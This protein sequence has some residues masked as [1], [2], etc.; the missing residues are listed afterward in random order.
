MLGVVER[1]LRLIE[2]QILWE[3]AGRSDHNIR[4]F[5][6]CYLIHFIE[7][8]A[9][10]AV[11]FDIMARNAVSNFLVFIEHDVDDEINV[12]KGSHLV[13]DDAHGVRIEVARVRA[14]P[15]PSGCDWTG[16][17]PGW[18]RRA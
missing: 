13:N 18:R 16:W 2:V 14:P 12:D 15:P 9:A 11:R 1:L 4:L 7:Q 8:A 5:R 10:R 6:N 3:A 17:P